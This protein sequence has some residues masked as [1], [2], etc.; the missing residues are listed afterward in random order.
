[1]TPNNAAVPPIIT[2]AFNSPMPV[3][4]RQPASVQG[5]ANT[6]PALAGP[7]PEAMSSKTVAAKKGAAKK[8]AAKKGAAK[9]GAAKKGAAKGA[10]PPEATAQDQAEWPSGISEQDEEELGSQGQGAWPSGVS[11]R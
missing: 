9:K 10:A 11:E 5:C 4:P 7:E 3:R 2:P 6:L 1:M 8:G